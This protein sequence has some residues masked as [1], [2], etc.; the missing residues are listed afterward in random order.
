MI[1]G[2]RLHPES[3]TDDPDYWFSR[4]VS[5]VGEYMG[6]PAEEWEP[7]RMARHTTTFEVL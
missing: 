7:V 3:K 4:L 6:V 2:L 5:S 1:R